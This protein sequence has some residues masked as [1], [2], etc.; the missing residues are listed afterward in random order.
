[1]DNLLELQNLQT[2]FLTERGYISALRKVSF[3]MKPHEVMGL[4]GESGCGKSVTTKSILR[5]FDESSLVRYEGKILYE[6]EDLLAMPL[7]SMN[8]IRGK[9][10]G[11]IFQDALT[12]LDPLFTVED[13]IVETIRVHQKKSRAEARMDALELLKLCGIPAPSERMKAYPHQLSGGMQ[14]RVMTAIALSSKPRLL[15]A[16]EPTTALDVTIQAQILDLFKKLNQEIGMAILFI[17]HDLALVSEFCQRV[18]VMYLG[19]IVEMADAL[20]IFRNPLHPYTQGLMRSIPSLQS[21]RK[22]KLDTIKGAVPSL[23]EDI[24]GCTFAGRCAYAF[25]K[26]RVVHPTLE[27]VGCD[28]EVSCWLVEKR[29]GEVQE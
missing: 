19:E 24:Q 4:V 17:T 6:G 23:H 22:S 1:M 12:S 11:M 8:K 28:H 2:H 27:N 20:T 15:L 7:K 5:L 26:C 13:Q 10:I 9:E 16:D 14:Q 18:A 25:D 29:R 3:S 21:E